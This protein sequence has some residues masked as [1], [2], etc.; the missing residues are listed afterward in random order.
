MLNARCTLGLLRDF[1]GQ[2]VLDAAVGLGKWAHMRLL[3]RALTEQRV[4]YLPS[5][6]RVV[7]DTFPQWAT[8]FPT[9]FLQLVGTMPLQPEPEVMG[10]L[11]LQDVMLPRVLV[12]GS[13]WRCP[14]ALWLGDLERYSLHGKRVV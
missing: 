8:K 14:R 5:P 6:M 13:F 1:D 12:R 3:L 2:S 10:G 9:D 11:L 4:L 7:S